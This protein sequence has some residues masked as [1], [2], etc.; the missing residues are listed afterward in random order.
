MSADKVQAPS[1]SGQTREERAG[2]SVCLTPCQ[3][4]RS[5]NRSKRTLE[6]ARA[7]CGHHVA[8]PLLSGSFLL[9]EEDTLAS[10][11]FNRFI[12]LQS[13]RK[14]QK[15]GY[16]KH[17]GT[18]GPIQEPQPEVLDEFICNPPP[19]PKEP[20]LLHK[21]GSRMMFWVGQ[22]PKVLRGMEYPPP[23]HSQRNSGGFPFG[24]CKLFPPKTSINRF[25]FVSTSFNAH[26][27]YN[28]YKIR[29]IKFFFTRICLF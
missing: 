24:N 12:V 2:V 15:K 28:R 13:W 5:P 14:S 27:H 7:A 8:R 23:H 4:G 6:R 18:V 3:A 22:L 21:V 20:A 25:L 11:T 16:I 10:D 29:L 17:L 9:I 1:L 19:P 26:R